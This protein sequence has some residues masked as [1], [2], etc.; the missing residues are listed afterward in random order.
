MGRIITKG[1]I[2][3][4]ESTYHTTSNITILYVWT[5]YCD[6][7][8]RDRPLLWLHDFT[9]EIVLHVGGILHNNM[10]FSIMQNDKL[11]IFWASFLNIIRTFR[12]KY[13]TFYCHSP[14][15]WTLELALSNECYISC[16]RQIICSIYDILKLP[17]VTTLRFVC[18][19]PGPFAVVC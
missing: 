13:E 4:S 12:L 11:I 6:G 17:C 7:I 10:I 9:K 14:K 16:K 18:F 3:Y 8:A 2:P 15:Y 19:Y 1:G 5:M